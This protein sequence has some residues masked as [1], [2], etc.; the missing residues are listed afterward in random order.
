MTRTE[1]ETLIRI[2]GAHKAVCSKIVNKLKTSLEAIPIDLSDIST[3]VKLAEDKLKLISD[4]SERV[5]VETESED[6]MVADVKKECEYAVQ[7]KR[8]VETAMMALKAERQVK[9][10]EVVGLQTGSKSRDTLEAQRES[11]RA[12]CGEMVKKLKEELSSDHPNASTI[13]SY[14]DAINKQVEKVDTFALPIQNY[15]TNEEYTADIQKELVFESEVKADLHR[16]AELLGEDRSSI[17]TS[18]GELGS[19]KLPALSLPR[20]DN[21]CS[22]WYSFWD[23]FSAAVD[24]MEHLDEVNKLTYL[25]GQVT[26]EAKELIRHLPMKNDSYAIAI[27]ILKESFE[28]KLL[29]SMELVRKL[30]RIGNIKH[31]T[32]SL[33]NFR[34]DLSGLLGSLDN[35]GYKMTD[36]E[37]AEMLITALMLTRMP[38]SL[39][40]SLLRTNRDNITTFAGFSEAINRE[41]ELLVSGGIAGHGGERGGSKSSKISHQ[42]HSLPSQGTLSKSKTVT[43]NFHVSASNSKPKTTRTQKT[44]PKFDKKKLSKCIFCDSTEHK[45]TFCEQFSAIDARKSKLKEKGRCPS[46]MQANHTGQACNVKCFGC[47]GNHALPVCHERARWKN[48]QSAAEST[49]TQTNVSSESQVTQVNVIC[50]QNA[51]VLPHLLVPVKNR[52]PQVNRSHVSVSTLLDQ[53][54]QRTFILRK[55]VE[56]LN[57]RSLGYERLVIGTLAGRQPEKQFEV[58]E[59]VLKRDAA[60]VILKGIVVDELPRQ[61]FS[62]GV[63]NKVMKLQRER[64]MACTSIGMDGVV[65]FELLVGADFYWDIVDPGQHVIMREDVHLVPTYYGYVLSGKVGSSPGT[66]QQNVFSSVIDVM[67]I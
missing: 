33:R 39:L 14:V 38:Q 29:I 59:M 31:N 65:D 7:V 11:H 3:Q 8:V 53:G 25:M 61:K 16:A 63:V 26:G 44:A 47:N 22:G 48:S 36:H 21:T 10:S 34:A 52:N 30:D 49:V 27:K 45:P 57:L 18:R 13:T 54:S 5:L 66:D 19:M 17:K 62:T 12:A 15:L 67:S 32:A 64:K 28:N 42:K 40:D 41:I 58:V 50:N 4:Y 43:D 60:A 23:I 20:F 6:E 1:R 46:C 51:V 24:R 37:G 55:T 35:V 2:R 9:D 56:K